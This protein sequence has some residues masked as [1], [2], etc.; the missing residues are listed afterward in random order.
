MWSLLELSIGVLAA[1]LPTLKPLF[2][3]ALPRLFR[4]TLANLSSAGRRGHQ[5]YRDMYGVSARQ[6]GV[7]VVGGTTTASSATVVAGKGAAMAGGGI[8]F[9]KV[10]PNKKAGDMAALRG[11]DDG[12]L[13]SGGDGDI[14]MPT[15]HVS[16]TGGS[17]RKE[18]GPVGGVV[19]IHTTTTVT[20]RVDSL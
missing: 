4:S 19:G 16:V 11:S 9:V 20:Q 3:L 7:S 8:V 6:A 14:E 12:S 15:Y 5:Q 10:D 13:G 1:C 2:A 18:F 17:P